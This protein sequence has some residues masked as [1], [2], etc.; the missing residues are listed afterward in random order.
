MMQMIQRLLLMLAFFEVSMQ[1]VHIPGRLNIGAD[2]ISWDNLQVFHMQV[3]EAHTRPS[4]VPQALVHQQTSNRIGPSQIGPGC[5]GPVC[6]RSS[7]VY[8]KGL[9]NWKGEVHAVL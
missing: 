6:S 7:G 5:S 3:P 1:T 8:E 2:A 9:Q 4:P